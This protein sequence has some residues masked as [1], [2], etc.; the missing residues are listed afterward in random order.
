[1]Q[2][3]ISEDL[4]QTPMGKRANKVIRTCVHCG[5]CLP[6]CPTYQILGDELTRQEGVF[7]SSSHHWKIIIFLRKVLST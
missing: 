5:F 7:I 6:T 3:Q 1:M 4:L 2:T